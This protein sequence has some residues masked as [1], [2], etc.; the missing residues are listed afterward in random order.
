MQRAPTVVLREEALGA[1]R[2]HD[3]VE[4]EWRLQHAASSLRQVEPE[5]TGWLGSAERQHEESC[6]GGACRTSRRCDAAASEVA[7]RLRAVRERIA[8][9]ARAAGRDPAAVTLVAVGK[10]QPAARIAGRARRRPARVRREL[11]AGGQG[12]LGDDACRLARSPA[13][14]G[15]A[16]SDQQGQGRGRAVRRGRDARPAEA[17]RCPR[18]RDG[19]PGPPA[20]V[21]GPGQHRRGGAEGGRL[22]GGCRRVH[23]RLPRRS[24]PAGRRPDGDPARGRGA[25][26]ALR[27]ARQDRRAQPPRPAQHGHERRLRGRGPA[28][29]DPR[30][31]RQRAVRRPAAEPAIRPGGEAG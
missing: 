14:H 12:A 4:A 17:R 29:R 22:A 28:R 25:G 10:A 6:M 20:G 16:D 3:L 15:R 23:R 27:A 13:A 24:R 26:A 1:E 30:P 9:A 18:P 21:P 11:R 7:E 8:A 19:A 31:G 2:R 5:G